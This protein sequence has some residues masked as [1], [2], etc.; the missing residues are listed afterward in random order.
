MED[1]RNSCEDDDESSIDFTVSTYVDADEDVQTS[2][3]NSMTDQE[4]I[5]RV[6]SIES[7]DDEDDDIE[8]I[9]Q[10]HRI[11]EPPNKREVRRTIKTL[12]QCCLF[13]EDGEMMRKKISEVEKMYESC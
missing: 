12:Q 11:I 9:D 7:E 2:E 6:R 8:E 13:Q 5:D 1:F 10:N 4:I 3:I